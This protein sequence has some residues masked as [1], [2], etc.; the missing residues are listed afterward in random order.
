MPL[1]YTDHFRTMIVPN[2]FPQ[3]GV[4]GS[5]SPT[6]VNARPPGVTH[7]ASLANMRTTFDEHKTVRGKRPVAGPFDG[8]RVIEISEGMGPP[9]GAMLLGDLGA[10]VVKVEPPQGDRVRGTPAFHVLNRSKR[11]LVA[12]LTTADGQKRVEPLLRGAD[13]AIIGGGPASHKARSLG[14]K[15]LLR[16][17]PQL[18]VILAPMYGLR[19]PYADLPEEE[20]LLGA[21]SGAYAHQASRSGKAIYQTIH[22]GM[23]GQGVLVALTAAAG[24]IKRERTGRGDVIEVSGLAAWYQYAAHIFLY[25]SIDLPRLQFRSASGSANY[26]FYETADHRWFFVG[27]P[28]PRDFIKLVNAFGIQDVLGD[29]KYAHGAPTAHP[30]EM[31]RLRERC[32]KIIRSHPAAYWEDRLIANDC[33]Y[34][35]LQS[36]EEYIQEEQVLI[37]EMVQEVKDPELGLTRQMG[38]SLNAYRSPGTIQ[39]PAPRLDPTA[40][41][42]AW[43]PRVVLAPSGTKSASPLPLEG[44]CS[45]RRCDLG[46]RQL[47]ANAPRRSGDECDQGRASGR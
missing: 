2:Y 26:G 18:I 23:A 9:L 38:I 46:R 16:A 33:A 19:G 13:V 32:Q 39:S 28:S 10:E 24:L 7:T 42:P 25:P 29:P 43:E 20:G 45:P 30:D 21:L 44:F 17:N 37:M 36:R 22:V 27:A 8:V 34:G 41:P 31:Q 3:A 11:G 14:A 4:D 6:L 40:P 15:A 47:R 35:F 1:H 5:P 12:D